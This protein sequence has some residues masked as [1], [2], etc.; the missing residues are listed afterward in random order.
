MIEPTSSAAPAD[1]DLDDSRCDEQAIVAAHHRM[2]HAAGCH[3]DAC[4]DIGLGARGNREGDRSRLW[5]AFEQQHDLTRAGITEDRV[6][7]VVFLQAH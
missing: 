5:V 3:A 6:V 4:G 7:N 2:N 1:Y